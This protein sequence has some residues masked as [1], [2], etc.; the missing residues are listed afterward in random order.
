[1]R[2]AP[3]VAPLPLRV[4]DIP[5]LVA[6][7]LAGLGVHPAKTAADEWPASTIRG[8]SPSGDLFEGQI[9]RAES[10]SEFL[11]PPAAASLPDDGPAAELDSAPPPD[12]WNAAAARLSAQIEELQA[13][14]KDLKAAPPKSDDKKKEEKKDKAW[15]EKLNIRGYTQFRYN[16]VLNDEGDA[17]PQHVGD[18]SVQEDQ[19]FL[20]RRARVILF[21]DV[22]DHLYVYLQPDFAVT[23]P[24]STD[25]IQF[26]QIRDWYGDIYFDD[27][28]E[29]RVRVGQSKV[30]Y[31]WENLQSSQN[32]LPLD[33]AD[34]LNS[35][36]RNE[37]DLGAFFYWT[38]TWA[39][40][41]FKYIMDEG[42]K[43]SGN[44][45]VFGIGAYAGQGGSL[46][47]QNDNVHLVTRLTLPLQLEDGQLVEFGVQ[48]YTGQYAVLST[49]IS[50]LGVGPPVRP[51]GTF[52]TGDA[53][54]KLDQR[55]AGSFIW[56]PQPWG[57]QS[58][59]TVGRGPA[60]DDAQTAV[61]DR[62][63]YGGYAMTM[64]RIQTE[65][66]GEL[67]PFARW[68]YF[69]GGYKSER[70]APWSHVNEWEL[71]LEWQISK[72]IEF[73]SMYTITDRTNTIARNVADTRSYQQF[74]GDL[75]RFQLQMNY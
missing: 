52:E 69:K 19:T 45:G 57:F 3:G 15:Y 73:V 2:A 5:L 59:W 1:M 66:C 6:L 33:R 30:P 11:A 21:G 71:G 8:Q 22:S 42:L 55:I 70:N 43:G 31:G 56:Y 32:R 10:S 47:E 29:Y 35:A 58:E 27:N 68:S 49:P 53:D 46:R 44:Y 34:P 67:W 7:A 51:T 74:Q 64:Y 24:G 4:R 12:D 65:S 54:G 17:P 16:A 61:T 41:R 63:L 50:P 25:G 18:F 23:P 20:I 75:L 38:P 26:L 9:P 28:K 40:D 14:L 62:P 72:S 48:A 36:V 37:R 39:Q 13:E 60:L